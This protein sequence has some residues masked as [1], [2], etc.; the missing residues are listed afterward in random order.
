VIARVHHS[1]ASAPTPAAAPTKPPIS[2]HLR[3]KV[4]PAQSSGALRFQSW[5][6]IT[7]IRETCGTKPGLTTRISI[8]PGAFPCGRGPRWTARMCHV[9][10]ALGTPDL[11]WRGILVPGCAGGG[12]GCGSAHTGA[13]SSGWSKP[14]GGHLQSSS[15]HPRPSQAFAEVSGAI[16]ILVS[17]SVKFPAQR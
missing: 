5:L 2:P 14:E 17:S 3:R 1:N 4:A 12:K 16:R 8:R 9:M 11:G 7:N 13:E 10:R 6:I 15:M